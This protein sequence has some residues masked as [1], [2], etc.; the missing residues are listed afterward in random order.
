MCSFFKKL[1]HRVISTSLVSCIPSYKLIGNYSIYILLI[2]R[3]I[4][5]LSISGELTNSAIFISNDSEY[6][7]QKK[8][9]SLIMASIYIG[10]MFGFISTLITMN[11]IDMNSNLS[12][13]IPFLFSLPIGIYALKI[14]YY[15]PDTYKH[16]IYKKK[17]IKD[18]FSN[19]NDIIMVS[20]LFSCLAISIYILIGYIPQSMM[21]NL[22]LSIN[23]SIL[24][25][26]ISMAILSICVVYLGFTK[27]KSIK[28]L[29][30]GFVCMTI[31]FIPLS[32]I[33]NTNIYLSL[34]AIICILFYLPLI[35][36]SIMDFSLNIFP[37]SIKC[38]ALSTGYNISMSIFGGSAPLIITLLKD[39]EYFIMMYFVMI[40]I[41]S[42]LAYV[43]FKK[44][45]FSCHFQIY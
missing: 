43:F 28:L 25:N 20:F 13:R 35:A 9:S 32:M 22:K 36:S 18:V 45:S 16:R 39:N 42:I 38:T 3:I 41:I 21:F 14:R 15:L 11:L 23:Y 33:L 17:Y 37:L 34:L 8:S 6:M 40:A 44:R 27:I 2:L 24:I 5:G 26:I 29:V 1:D 19:V 30:A 31:L 10:L 12:W 7:N 4:Q